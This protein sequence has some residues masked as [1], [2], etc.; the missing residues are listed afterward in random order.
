[1][2]LGDKNSRMHLYVDHLSPHFLCKNALLTFDCVISGSSNDAFSF[3]AG[4]LIAGF[5][6]HVEKD[7]IFFLAT[8]YDDLQVDFIRESRDI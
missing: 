8:V 7:D 3:L 5:A 6:E 2:C 4:S 1:M